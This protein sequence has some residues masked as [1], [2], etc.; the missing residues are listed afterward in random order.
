MNLC[1]SSIP[2]TAANSSHH[3]GVPNWPAWNSSQV[4]RSSTEGS[5]E[6]LASSFTGS[7]TLSWSWK[8]T[9]LWGGG[10]LLDWGHMPC[11]SPWWQLWLSALIQFL[12][13]PLEQ[14]LD[15]VLEQALDW[16]LDRPLLWLREQAHDLLLP[17]LSL[18][19]S[20]Q[21]ALV[22]HP[23]SHLIRSFLTW[24]SPLFHCGRLSLP[25]QLNC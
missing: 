24:S 18:L 13:Q 3:M 11:G 6:L 8:L 5:V 25:L 14:V 10:L 22:G 16:A 2:G 19:R 1:L 9:L 15:Q 20:L 23:G 7:F 4:S 21:R 17:L 12:D